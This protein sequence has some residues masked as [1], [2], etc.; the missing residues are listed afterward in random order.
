MKC[1][2]YAEMLLKHITNTSDYVNDLNEYILEGGQDLVAQENV[3]ENDNS[4]Y[5]MAHILYQEIEYLK[6]SLV[7]KFGFN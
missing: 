7:S 5:I 3:L 6:E 1:L 4:T 2:S